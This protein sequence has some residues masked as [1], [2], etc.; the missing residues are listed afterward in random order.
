VTRENLATRKLRGVADRLRGITRPDWAATCDAAA[1]LLVAP[2][3]PALDRETLAR[4]LH[5]YDMIA[6]PMLQPHPWNKLSDLAHDLY[7]EDA[8]AVLARLAGKES[9]DAC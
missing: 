9:P 8:D 7:H 1:A 3:R 5:T 4:A 6:H 2:E